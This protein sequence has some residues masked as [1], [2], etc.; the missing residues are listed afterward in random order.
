MIEEGVYP[1]GIF[2]A[3]GSRIAGLRDLLRRP[4]RGKLEEK[5]DSVALGRPWGAAGFAAFLNA[6]LG[7]HIAAAGFVAMSGNQPQSARFHEH[8]STGNGANTS[9]RSSYQL[10]ASQAASYT[11]ATIFGSWTPTYSQ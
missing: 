4:I 10:T 5:P 6:D 8:G 11:L 7:A 9:S 3:N 1:V 2:C